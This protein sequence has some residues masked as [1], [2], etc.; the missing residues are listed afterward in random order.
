[1]RTHVVRALFLSTVLVAALGIHSAPALGAR[2]DRVQE[3]SGTVVAITPGSRTIVIQ[4][5]LDGQ[6]WTVGAEVPDDTR[7][8]GRAKDLADLHEG[9]RVTMR[10][11]T[12]ENGSV[13]R[14]IIAR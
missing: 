14:A 6:P 8:D 11:I 2:E 13:A 3:A 9:D 7:F 5:T 1:M 10:W 4:S 12:E